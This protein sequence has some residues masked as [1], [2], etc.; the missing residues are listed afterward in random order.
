MTSSGAARAE[1]PLTR[2]RSFLALL[3]ATGISALGTG[4]YLP[5]IQLL[6]VQLTSDEKAVAALK[7]AT[8]L[9]AALV[10]LFS[11]VAA[12][13]MRRRA[14]M[15]FSD[16]VRAA[17]ILGF[18]LLVADDLAALWPMYVVAVVLGS[19]QTVFDSA[20]QAVLPQVVPRSALNRANSLLVSSW[21]LGIAFVGP[22]LGG[23]LFAVDHA[24][25]FFVNAGTFVVSAVLLI[26][27]RVA[28]APAAH[29]GDALGQNSV[30]T[31]LRIGVHHVF[32]H[33][34]LRSVTVI[35]AIISFC[36]G[37]I[38]S[39]F[40]LF[41]TRWLGLDAVGYGLLLVGEAVGAFLGSFLAVRLDGRV[42]RRLI[43]RAAPLLIGAMYVLQ[44]VTA[45]LALAF[46][47][48]SAGNAMFMVWTIVATSVRQSVG[49]NALLG[50]IT[51]VDRLG[52]LVATGAGALVG[53]AVAGGL[54]VQAPFLLS[55]VLLFVLP[56]CVSLRVDEHEVPAGLRW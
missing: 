13:R 43:I 34:V 38:T 44:A 45:S 37:M 15:I 35:G 56:L 5:A 14:L 9:P 4:L 31:D 29:G 10:I 41:A 22:A 16:L 46:V 30:T 42:S 23:V 2:N 39:V 50:R 17:A 25:P 36:V 6:A 3:A 12:D 48:V 19:T 33:R 52:G 53:G 51:S 26:W 27:I 24:L 54:G 8:V 18:A 40:V 49:P 7:V 32:R 28:A 47:V 55:A 21:T 11:G 20:A 1:P